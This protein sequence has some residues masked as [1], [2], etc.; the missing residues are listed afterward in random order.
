MALRQAQDA[1]SRR[2]LI[3]GGSSSGKSRYAESIFAFADRVTYIAPGAVPDPAVDAEWAERIAAH[4]R[5]RSGHWVTVETTDIITALRTGQPPLLLDCLGTWLARF[6][7]ELGAWDTPRP[8]WQPTFDT[9]LD[10]LVDAWRSVDG[11]AVA[12]TNE[13]GWGLVSEHRS[14]RL[15]TDLLGRLNAS[16][17]RGQRR[18][19]P[20]GGRSGPVDLSSTQALSAPSSSTVN[21]VSTHGSDHV[22]GHPAEALHAVPQQQNHSHQR[23]DDRHRTQPPARADPG[24]RRGDHPQRDQPADDN[25]RARHRARHRRA[26]P[27]G[28]CRRNAP[29]AAQSDRRPG[30]TDDQ[31]QQHGR[32]PASDQLAD[33]NGLNADHQDQR[34]HAHRADVAAT[35]D[36]QRPFAVP[37]GTQAVDRVG[38]TVQVQCP[39]PERQHPHS[40]QAHQQRRPADRRRRPA[41][42]GRPDRERGHG[43]RR[44][45][46]RPAGHRRGGSRETDWSHGQGAHGQPQRRPGSPHPGGARSA[47]RAMSRTSR[48]ADWSTGSAARAPLPS[49]SRSPRSRI[50][51]RPNLSRAS[52]CDGSVDR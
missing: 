25:G 18:G 42:S 21:A 4:R 41:G 17:G 48:T 43:Q 22:P 50:G 30:S 37:A 29:R 5:R 8:A 26:Q 39:G 1:D 34:Q 15:F 28:P 49:P 11:P 7:D 12:V 51:S 6:L 31:Q 16:D 10:A 3:T 44:Q 19:D 38:Q 27:V 52:R 46:H 40:D 35:H 36:R 45:Q 2:I 23:R 32:R 14:G 13:V 47:S 33:G 9:R 20:G 24:Q